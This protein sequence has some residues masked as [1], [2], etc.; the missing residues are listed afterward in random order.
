[1]FVARRPHQAA[2]DL[3]IWKRNLE[4]EIQINKP[5]VIILE[6]WNETSNLE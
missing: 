1:M 5:N 4:K 2:S 6:R 3:L